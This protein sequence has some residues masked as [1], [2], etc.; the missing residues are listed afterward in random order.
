MLDAVIGTL[1]FERAG[2][3][4]CV[5]RH[6]AGGPSGLNTFSLFDN[7]LVADAAG[8]PS[9]RQRLPLVEDHSKRCNG[10]Y[11]RHAGEE[12]L[13]RAEGACDCLCRPELAN[14]P[15]EAFRT[16]PFRRKNQRH[17]R[18]FVGN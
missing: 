5:G 8:L 16:L 12:C 15:G 6:P 4:R 14:A 13:R 9:R 2:T 3:M 7:E 10:R 1:E 17:A 18:R 11:G